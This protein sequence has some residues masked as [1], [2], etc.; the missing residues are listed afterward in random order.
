[1]RVFRLGREVYIILRGHVYKTKVTIADDQV[2]DADLSSY[3]ALS[4]I[5]SNEYAVT[6]FNLNKMYIQWF[7]QNATW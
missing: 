3:S 2:F 5:D 1:M 7:G 4:Q 6:Y